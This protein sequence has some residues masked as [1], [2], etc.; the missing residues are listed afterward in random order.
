[1]Q[2]HRHSHQRFGWWI[3]TGAVLL[4][5][6]F[7]LVVL[8]W[9]LAAPGPPSSPTDW[10]N[11]VGTPLAYVGLVGPVVRWMVRQAR[12]APAITSDETVT[13]RLRR[14]VR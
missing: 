11:V 6:G 9:L 4:A 3:G 8:L 5:A 2:P 10:A 1:M 14:A 7:G 12:A 13:I